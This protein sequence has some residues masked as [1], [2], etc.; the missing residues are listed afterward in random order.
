MD[1]FV[2]YHA[3]D[4]K[5]AEWIGECLQESGHTF[6]LQSY[7]YWARSSMILEMFA[8][9]AIAD[10]TI[11]VLSPDFLAENLDRPEWQAA[12]AQDPTAT[13]GILIPVRVRECDV[14]MALPGVEYIDLVGLAEDPAESLRKGLAMRPSPGSAP[15]N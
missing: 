4:Q 2:A 12:C 6:E 7:D 3:A 8:V 14:E 13:L 10:A 11:A 9:S 15:S 5:W 1:Y